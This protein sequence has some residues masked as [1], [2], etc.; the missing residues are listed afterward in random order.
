MGSDS[1]FDVEGLQTAFCEMVPH[2]RALGLRL[3]H[4]SAAEAA[5]VIQL[6]WH[7]RLIGNPE[8]RMTHGGAISTLLDA[9]CGM[10]VYAK[11]Q[12][13]IPIATLDLRVDS[14]RL[15]VPD[16]DLFARAECYK[17][18]RTIAFVR[19]VAYQDEHDPVASAAATFMLS[20]KGSGL[21]RAP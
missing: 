21:E 12:T 17:A 1:V 3:L 14:L 20:T 16:R 9:C 18:T 10:A 8:T 5:A 6:P 2:N 11:L 13:A 15:A 4:V 7:P 19:A